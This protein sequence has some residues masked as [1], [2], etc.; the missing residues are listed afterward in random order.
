MDDPLP[1]AARPPAASAA[2]PSPGQAARAGRPAAPREFGRLRT[3]DHHHALDWALFKHGYLHG[4]MTERELAAALRGI[5]SGVRFELGAMNP[6]AREVWAEQ[7]WHA[8]I[9]CGLG[10]GPIWMPT[11]LDLG[12]HFPVGKWELDLPAIARQVRRAFAGLDYLLLLEVEIHVH[13]ARRFVAPHPHG[14]LFVDLSRR[15]YERVRSCFAGGVAGTRPLVV[16][17]A[18]GPA[19]V[20]R[21]ALKPQLKATTYYRSRTDQLFHPARDLTLPEHFFLWRHLHGL[22]LPELVIA[23]GKG[24]RVLGAAL[25]GVDEL[26]ER[27][28]PRRHPGRR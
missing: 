14:L 6:F 15:Q 5:S 4:D 10:Q 20:F 16:K 2:S 24:R 27:A 18:W 1:R 26:A 13:L 25:R 3:A 11:A 9:T 22:A 23:G 21:Y 8:V 7:L 17:P 19:G 12:W 28:H